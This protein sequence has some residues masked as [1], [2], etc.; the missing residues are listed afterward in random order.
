MRMDCVWRMC[1]VGGVWIEGGFRL[2]VLG[3]VGVVGGSLALSQLK[4]IPRQVRLHGLPQGR[5]VF[6]FVV[7][8]TLPRAVVPFQIGVGTGPGSPQVG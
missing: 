2:V 7:G 8:V 6:R 1:G 4:A 3:P 5:V